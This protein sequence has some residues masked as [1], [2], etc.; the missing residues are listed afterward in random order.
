MQSKLRSAASSL[1]ERITVVAD[2]VPTK[3][4]PREAW[5]ALQEFYQGRFPTDYIELMAVF[6]FEYV[7]LKYHYLNQ[8]GGNPEYRDVNFR[9]R[10]PISGL[11][12]DP[13]T[14]E[15]DDVRDRG[16]VVLGEG[17]DG[18]LWVVRQDLGVGGAVYYVSS[19]GWDRGPLIL[20]ESLIFAAHSLA[21]LIAGFSLTDCDYGF[22][23][24]TR[25]TEARLD[26][27][28][29]FPYGPEDKVRNQDA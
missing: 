12:V 24:R 27:D 19:T 22:N 16:Y 9:F 25:E 13:M 6:P 17:H 29:F 8:T 2:S 10:S 18:D 20:G 15:D 7:S 11:G 1:L 28:L 4:T 3:T 23:H 14:G 26:I 21:H 5:R